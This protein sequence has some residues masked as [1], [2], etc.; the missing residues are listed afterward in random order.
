MLK[1]FG[2]ANLVLIIISGSFTFVLIDLKNMTIFDYLLLGVYIMVV[3]MAVIRFFLLR[4]IEQKSPS[5]PPEAV[6]EEQ[7]GNKRRT[8]RNRT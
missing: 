3:V 1:K 7:S 2:I 4:K 5:N 8:K 6:V